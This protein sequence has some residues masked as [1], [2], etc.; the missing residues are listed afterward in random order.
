MQCFGNFEVYLDGIP[1]QFEFS[2]SKE[3]LAYLIDRR[4]ALCSNHE[5]MA[6]IF[7]KDISESYFRRIRLDLLNA[8]SEEFFVR[9]R[10]RIAVNTQFFDCDYYDY[11]NG[12]FPHTAITEYMSQYS[13][14]E[15]K[16]A[17]ILWKNI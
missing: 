12:K 17:D 3:M 15:P 11:L 5:I 16:L 6:V 13:W 2:K 1:V 9:Q 14:G 7:E 10:G 8:L 4:G